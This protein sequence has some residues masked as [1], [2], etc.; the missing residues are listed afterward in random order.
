MFTHGIVGNA[1]LALEQ[2]PFLVLCHLSMSMRKL[3]TLQLSCLR[4][5]E[6]QPPKGKPQSL[7][8]T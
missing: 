1:S 8:V 5:L 7:F 4:E 2:W 6:G 3:T